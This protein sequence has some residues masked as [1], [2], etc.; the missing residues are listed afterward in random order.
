MRSSI[1]NSFFTVFFLTVF[2]VGQYFQI[3]ELRAQSDIKFTGK[4]KMSAGAEYSDFLQNMINS[5]NADHL[6][7]N[8]KIP[9]NPMQNFEAIATIDGINFDEDAANAG[10]YFIPPDPHG[11]VGP[12]RLVSVVNTSIEWHTKAGVQEVSKR[13]G[14]DAVTHI[15]S[16]FEP[17]VPVN[18]LFDPKVIFDQHAGRFVVVALEQVSM[19]VLD[20]PGNVSRIL[21][22]VSDDS[23]P[24]GLWYYHA[25]PSKLMI[26]AADGFHEAW[27]DYPGLAVDEEAVYIT[28]NMFRFTGGSSVDS[29]IWIMDK[30][31]F[32]AGGPAV[33]SVYD[34]GT[35]SGITPDPM[36]YPTTQ[37]AHVF[38]PGL[39][40]G[41][42]GTYLVSAG[43]ADGMGIDYL[44]IIE[45]TSP[46]A[47]PVFSFFFTPLGDIHTGAAFPDAPQFGSMVP[48]ETNDNRALHAVW[49]MGTLWAVNCIMPTAPPNIGQVTA[50]W[51]RISAPGYS[52]VDQGDVG[53]E[54]IAPG[55]FTF[56][57]SIAVNSVTDMALGF[58]ASAPSIFGGAY[59]TGR[60]ST[61]PVGVGYTI[62]S[63]VVRPGLDSY[64]RTFGGP[65]N[66]WGDYSATCVDPSDDLTF[67]VFNEYADTLGTFLPPGE[68]GRWST[69]WG[70]LPTSVLPVELASFTGSVSGSTIKLSW[71]TKTEVN[72]Y[73]FEIEK[74]I[75]GKTDW[76]KIGFI[77]GS[78][79]SNS[80]K[81]YSFMDK[82]I[83]GAS[84]FNYRL[85]QLD[86]DG[87]Y[88]YSKVIEVKFVPEKF[89]LLQNY[90]NPFNPST[91]IS[92]QSPVGS[93]Q[94][95]KIFDVLGNEVA[96]LMDEYREAGKYEVDFDASGLASGIYY[97][98]LQSGS[99]VE[100][101]KMMLIR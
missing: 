73:G 29:R 21:V 53:G 34:H 20:H 46:L 14:K 11:A 43:W 8:G 97:Y 25:I 22:A 36:V 23:D 41:M 33:V 85:K 15:G 66:R 19:G 35:L 7:F 77:H 90:P 89:A 81:K 5:G 74:T 45:I 26:L 68:D 38:G 100:T 6:K 76:Q 65:K 2:L 86:T 9:R 67:Y 80:P 61:D 10:F 83:I 49:R 56:F 3:G 79:N 72:N 95:L 62:P 101:K 93:N 12:T 31:P 17:L 28:A 44:N 48:I 94:T 60:L 52:I 13:L 59:F 75:S 63:D 51:Y 27:A 50:H 91:K 40:P 82:N 37:P 99:F 54:E 57:P 58:A 39:P 30:I 87:K 47:G 69:A 1:T 24:N 32:Y 4:V 70:V 16:F 55:C 42:T 71:S 18:A 92:W 84:S 98:K 88:K 96:V 78:G 64:V